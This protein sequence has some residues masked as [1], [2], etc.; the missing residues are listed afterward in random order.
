MQ[1]KTNHARY[2]LCR[3]QGG[4]NDMLGEIEKCCHYADRTNRVV[5]VDTDY[6]YATSFHDDL[7]KYFES[8]RENLIL[9]INGFED[10]INQ[11]D[12]FPRFLGGRLFSYKTIKKWPTD[13]MIDSISQEF[14]SFDFNEEYSEKLLVH[15][16][17]G[18]AIN[19]HL[20]FGK[21][22]LK[23]NLVIELE[24]RLN[25]IGGPYL[26]IHIRNTD[27]YSDYSN[28]LKSMEQ[29]KLEKI[30]IASDN[31]NTANDLKVQLKNK[32]TFSFSNSI[33]VDNE[34]IHLKLNL[35]KDEIFIRNVDS[36]L[37]LLMLALSKKL[38]LV[39][40]CGR[41]GSDLFPVF[42][43]YSILALNLRFTSSILI[44]FLS[45]TKIK[46]SNGSYIERCTFFIKKNYL[47]VS[48]RLMPSNTNTQ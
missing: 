22:K 40:I 34:P 2:I 11:L 30:F 3:P 9:S 29:Q 37:D 27:Y 33:S 48:R 12:V 24:K 31:K 32:S 7:N 5:I 4:L 25:K 6:R 41:K 23:K 44:H 17:T 39:P 8:T 16:A 20:I 35:S 15:H 21:L 13:F 38:T 43:G 36:I 46:V 10:L 45:N 26:G 28:V 14:I 18:G 47:V 42:S 1:N 19:S